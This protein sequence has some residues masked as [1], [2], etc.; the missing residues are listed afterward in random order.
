FSGRCSLMTMMSS[1]MS[2]SVASTWRS[3]SFSSP[4]SSV[5]SCM[6]AL[7]S[8]RPQ[9]LLEINAEVCSPKADRPIGHK[10]GVEVGSHQFL[11]GCSPPNVN[12]SGPKQVCRP[13]QSY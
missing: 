10:E 12:Q 4:S 6:V 3:R 9:L 5:S 1:L 13:E 11:K 7:L 2:D 8:V